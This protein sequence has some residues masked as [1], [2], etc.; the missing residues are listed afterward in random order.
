MRS[1]QSPRWKLVKFLN[2]TRKDEFYD[3]VKD[4][5]ELV[6]LIDSD[7]PQIRAAIED[8]DLR[9]MQQIRQIY[10]DPQR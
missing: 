1:F 2:K 9:L 3:R 5:E 6:N 4:P 10:G 7:D 8:F